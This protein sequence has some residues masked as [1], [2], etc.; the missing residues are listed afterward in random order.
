V[1]NTVEENCSIFSECAG[2]H[3]QWHAGSDTLHQQNPPVLN[4]RCQ[5]AQVDLHDGCETVVIVLLL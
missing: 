1:D 5:L 2:C 4:W 3:Q